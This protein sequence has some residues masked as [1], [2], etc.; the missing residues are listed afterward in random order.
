QCQQI[1]C[2]N[3]VEF[4]RL[5]IT[6]RMYIKNPN[7]GQLAISFYTHNYDLYYHLIKEGNYWHRFRNSDF[8]DIC[9]F[10]SSKECYFYGYVSFLGGA[11]TS[12][13]IRY[14]KNIQNIDYEILK[15]ILN[16][17]VKSYILKCNNTKNLGI[18]AEDIY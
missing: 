18:I 6:A 9:V 4:D 13:S 2:P 12:S 1:N 14:K 5:T 17:N 10:R 16:V 8:E 11:T 15:E 3:E 7:D